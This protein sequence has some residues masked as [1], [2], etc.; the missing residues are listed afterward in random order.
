VKPKQKTFMGMILGIVA[1][2]MFWSGCATVISKDVLREVNRDISF[3]DLRKDPTEYIGEMVLLGGVI[4]KV[5]Y[6]E[7]GTLLEIYQTAI[8]DQEEPV[9]LDV[10]QGRFLARYKGFLESGIYGKGRKVTIAG[11][12]EGVRVLKIGGLD[13]HYPYLFIKEIHLWEKEQKVYEPYPWYPMGR[14]GPW[15]PWGYPYYGYGPW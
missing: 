3:G 13:Y 9:H 7:D 4:V 10:S 14:R 8:D 5:T 6:K 2:A 15:G 12:V 11:T 1:V